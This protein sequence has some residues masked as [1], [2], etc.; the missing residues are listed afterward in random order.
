M[1]K[2]PSTVLALCPTIVN[3][4]KWFIINCTVTWYYYHAA[5]TTIEDIRC[6]EWITWPIACTI[7]EG[8]MVRLWS[9]QRVSP[10]HETII[11]LIINDIHS[12]ASIYYDTTHSIIISSIGDVFCMS[13]LTQLSLSY[14]QF[15]TGTIHYITHNMFVRWLIYMKY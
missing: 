12:Q 15:H 3:T 10:C 8:V 11:I 13:T 4:V 5:L 7:I 14:A 9:Q 2:L 1:S 6:S